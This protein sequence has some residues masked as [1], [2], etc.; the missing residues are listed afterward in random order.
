MHQHGG[1]HSFLAYLPLLIII[2]VTLLYLIS[3]SLHQR[4]RGPWS[5]WRTASF[6]MGAL[7][8]GIAISPAIAHYAH[9]DIRM[10]MFQHILIGMLAPLG[11]VLA[12]PLTLT[13]RTLP[14][15]ASQWLV[16]LLHCE[17]F[18]WVSHPLTALLLNV[19]GMYLLYL[20]PIYLLSLENSWLHYAVHVHFLLAGYL[21]TWAIAGPDPA[22]RRPGMITRITVLVI[23]IALHGIL[24]KLMYIHLLPLHSPFTDEAIRSAA[25]IMYYGGDIAELLLAIALFYSWYQQRPGYRHLSS[26]HQRKPLKNPQSTM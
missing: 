13:L 19:G 1:T 6:F 23:A 7:L 9:Q 12:A 24:G 11:L 3:A 8:L 5:Y 20:T 17:F 10:H 25:K 18:V 4:S 14:T 2:S 15:H 26:S 16:R 22:P 21:F